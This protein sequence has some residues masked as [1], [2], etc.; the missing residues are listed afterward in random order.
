MRVG[1]EIA[2]GGL[3]SHSIFDLFIDRIGIDH[4]P[5]RTG[6]VLISQPSSAAEV[7]QSVGLAIERIHLG[8]R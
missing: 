2:A 3:V 6:E 7:Y 8:A 1:G 4:D 5:G